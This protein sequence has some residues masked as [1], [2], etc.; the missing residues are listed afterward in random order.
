[1]NARQTRRAR[2]L[3]ARKGYWKARWL[4]MR[5]NL[6]DLQLDYT[7]YTNEIDGDAN[8]DPGLFQ[9]YRDRYVR[10]SKKIAYYE[11]KM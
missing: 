1:M 7:T 10:I 5:M 11:R 6:R 9:W 3:I 4:Q 2:R 8:M